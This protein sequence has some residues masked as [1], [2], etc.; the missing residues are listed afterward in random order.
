ML[1]SK[2]RKEKLF[3]HLGDPPEPWEKRVI[4]PAS[5]IIA[6]GWTKDSKIFLLS[7][8]GY[9]VINP[10]TGEIEIRNWDEDNSANSNFSSDN[11]E[12]TISELN[13]TVRVFGL[14]GGNG[15]HLT[16]DYWNLDS[17]CP[18]LGQQI[19]GLINLEDKSNYPEYW[20]N[21][22]LIELKRLEYFTLTYGFSP[23]EKCFGI[24][25][26]GGAEVFSRE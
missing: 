8:N 6:G 21:F 23:N 16:S 11:L 25:G 3:N 7:S 10:L 24:F 13:E 17:F 4:I 15:N 9:S 20:R 5:G 12:Y 18:G 2:K 19:V 1:F 14:R 26:S 22:Y